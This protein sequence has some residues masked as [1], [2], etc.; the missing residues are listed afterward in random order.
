MT[1][2]GVRANGPAL[3]AS[4]ALAAGVKAAYPHMGPDDLRVLTAPVQALVGLAT[5]MEFTWEAG[6][7]Y[8]SLADRF[9]IAKS[10]TGVNFLLA[11]FGLLVF[12]LI[13]AAR[14]LRTK[15]LLVPIAAAG[16]YAATVIVNA[17]RIA[18]G[19]ALHG[20]SWGWMD[21]AR[22]HR[23]AGIAVYLAALVLLHRAG[24]ALGGPRFDP[25]RVAST[26]LFAPFSAYAIVTIAVPLANGALAASP[27]LFAEHCA[28]IALAAGVA[29]AAMRRL[30]GAR[31]N[32]RP[33]NSLR[34]EYEQ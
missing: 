5:G 10:C 23:L 2:A 31:A 17:A 28:W 13:P 19:I 11:A 18:A 14:D 25:R 34:N 1:S 3:A 7:G 9:V 22:V 29:F 8:V 6:Y 15:V 21:A 33:P 32:S 26:A 24:R 4:L 27:R 30:D 12:T 16:A 20:V